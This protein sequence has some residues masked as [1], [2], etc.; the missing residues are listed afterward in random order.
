MKP[1]KYELEKILMCNMFVQEILKGI[2]GGDVIKYGFE[3]F[4]FLMQNQIKLSVRFRWGKTR[5]GS[6]MLY[7]LC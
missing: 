6:F 7:V 3:H 1:R 2:L 5:L 4:I